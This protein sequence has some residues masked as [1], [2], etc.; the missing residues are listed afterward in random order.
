MVSIVVCFQQHV[1][2]FGQHHTHPTKLH[3]FSQSQ[4]QAICSIRNAT[5][6]P[7]PT[8]RSVFQPP[9]LSRRRDERTTVARASSSWKKRYYSI[10]IL[11]SCERLQKLIYTTPQPQQSLSSLV[12][13]IDILF[14]R[15]QQLLRSRKW[16]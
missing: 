16:T 1:A 5:K 14:G 11:L 12:G 9:D 10:P 3:H 6:S 13:N 8:K 15:Q 4:I 7:S 2:Y